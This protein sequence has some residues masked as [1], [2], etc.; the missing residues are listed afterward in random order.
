ME[1]G[2]LFATILGGAVIPT[3]LAGKKQTKNKTKKQTAK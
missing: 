3:S 1:H 2:G